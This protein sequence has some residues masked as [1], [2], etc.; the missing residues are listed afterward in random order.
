MVAGSEAGC[1]N[2]RP[3]ELEIFVSCWGVWTGRLSCAGK[4]RQWRESS[5]VRQLTALDVSTRFLLAT[6]RRRGRALGSALRREVT[7]LWAEQ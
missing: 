5:I 7:E 3:V 4:C 1:V 6:R 2:Q